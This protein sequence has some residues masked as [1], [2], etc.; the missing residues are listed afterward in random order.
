M[1]RKLKI[2]N[3]A[4]IVVAAFISTFSNHAIAQSNK[5]IVGIYEIKDISGNDLSEQLT[6]MIATSIAGTNKFR[7]MEREGL[8]SLLRE[9]NLAH[10]GLVTTNTPNKTGGFEGVDFLVYGTIT[11]INVKTESD[12][13]AN[14]LSSVLSSNSYNTPSCTNKTASLELDIKITDAETSEIRYVK[15][16]SEQ[17]KTATSCSG[18]QSIDSGLLLRAAADK[19]ASGLVTTIFPIQLA[20]A[21]ADGTYILNY[22]EGTLSSGQYLNIFSKGEVIRDPS[23]GDILGS[24][25]QK[26]G[27][28][29]VTEVIGKMS[30]AVAVTTF[31]TSPPIGSIL[32]PAS[33]QDIKALTKRK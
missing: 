7:V 24:T 19:V 26:L 6:A 3:F 4:Y 17:V 22:G 16:I 2:S 14:L 5:P 11:A 21:Q 25:E 29:R 1:S 13:G 30:K 32:R 8:D 9:Q 12:V 10:S 33:E 27:I 15:R 31:D 18:G 23:S 20:A 28:L